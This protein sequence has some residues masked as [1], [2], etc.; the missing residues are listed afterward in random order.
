MKMKNKRSSDIEL[1]ILILFPKKLKTN[2]NGSIM[3][4][5]YNPLEYIG[6]YA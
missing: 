5:E 6:V 1:E 2:T 3:R 4:N